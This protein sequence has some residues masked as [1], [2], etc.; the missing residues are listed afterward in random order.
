MKRRCM[1]CMY[2]F[3][4]PSGYENSNNVCP[5]C[6]Y[7]EN[8]PTTAACYIA[9]GVLL[10][11]RYSVGVVI[12]SG[13]FGITYKAWDNL[14]ETVVAIKEYFPKGLVTRTNN[15]TVTSS[16]TGNDE[17]FNNGKDRF[18]KEARS[19]ARYNRN[20]GIVSITDFFADND[21]VYMVMEYLDG[22]NMRDYMKQ[23]GTPVPFDLIRSMMDSVGR[24]LLAIHMDGLVHR[25]ISPD[26]IFLCTDGVFKLIDF[27]AV[28]QM[29]NDE[30]LSQ[31][32]ILKQGFAPVEQ[33]T[34]RGKIGPWTDIYSLGATIYNLATGKI[35]TES[36]ER[37]IQDD[38]IPPESLNGALPYS[39][40]T[41]LKKALAVKAEDRYQNVS[42]F[43][44]EL[45]NADDYSGVLYGSRIPTEE[46]LNSQTEE[47]VG[48]DDVSDYETVAYSGLMNRQATSD[49]NNS[50]EN[51]RNASNTYKSERFGNDKAENEEVKSFSRKIVNKEE[52]AE[53]EDGE[54]LELNIDISFEESVFGKQVE[55]VVPFKEECPL[56]IGHRDSS[57]TKCKG[58]GYIRSN[59]KLLIKVPAGIYTGQSICFKGLGR[60]GINGGKRGNLIVAIKVGDHPEFR[61]SGYDINSTQIVSPKLAKTGGT[62][63]VNTVYGPMNVELPPNTLDNAV[64]T[65]YGRG[66]PTLNNKHVRGNHYIT[67]RIG[68]K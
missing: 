51:N 14:L 50:H 40:C 13:G 46:E 19:L 5:Y 37:I 25:D 41:A 10:N 2:E 45:F 4:I 38:L 63:T 34:K 56:C 16:T 20:Q 66:I 32:V 6:G 11:N 54:N 33:Y 27:G 62:Y 36:V 8:T 64:I 17:A 43:Y 49:I 1:N 60:H 12:G 59:K 7:L 52:E 18:L 29:M 22:C 48:T 47:I 57:C 67:L 53:P 21:T 58:S 39:F 42:T 61:R 23:Y 3:I 44:S 9:P 55:L 35:P 31:T 26:N 24:A 15:M 65:I 68:K 30:G 28:K